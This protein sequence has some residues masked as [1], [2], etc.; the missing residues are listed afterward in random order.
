MRWTDPALPCVDTLV[1]FIEELEGPGAYWRVKFNRK[2]IVPR[3]ALPTLAA[4]R[5]LHDMGY[6]DDFY[7]V[8]VRPGDPFADGQGTL[9]VLRRLKPQQDT[10]AGPRLGMLEPW[11]SPAVVKRLLEYELRNGIPHDVSDHPLRPFLNFS[12][13]GSTRQP[14]KPQVRSREC[15]R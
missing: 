15:L 11:P 14:K 6:P 9:G 1:V 8:S 12:E 4:S 13:L 3:S 10:G 5:K 2:I 7:L